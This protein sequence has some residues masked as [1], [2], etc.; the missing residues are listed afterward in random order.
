MSPETNPAL[1][2]EQFAHAIDLLRADLR[3]AATRIENLEKQ[4]SDYESRIRML[5]ETATQF[6]FLASI[7]S[8]GGLLGVIALIRELVK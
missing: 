1:I 5:S 2:A 6:K 4:S 8:G 7:A 3:A